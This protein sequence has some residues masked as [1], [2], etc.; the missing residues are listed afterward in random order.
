MMVDGKPGSLSDLKQGMLVRVHASV[1]E[2]YDTHEVLKRTASTLLYEDAVEGVVQSV[3]P[4]GSSLVVLGQTVTITSATIVDASIPERNVLRLV[5]GRDLVELSGFVT[6]DGTIKGT[7]VELKTV[8]MKTQPPDYEV[9]GIIKNHRAAQKTFE[10][11][12][13]TID[14]SEAKLNDMPGQ[15]SDDW[16]GLLVDA[17]G[18]QV[19]SG[20]FGSS[21]VRMKANLVWPETLGSND[22]E[23]VQVE[24]FVTQELGSGNFSIGIVRVQTNAETQFEGGTLGNI[25][26]GVRLEVHGALVGGIVKATKVELK[27]TELKGTV[28]QVLSPGDFFLGN[29][30][31]LTDVGTIFTDGTDSDIQVGAQLEVYGPLLDGIVKAVR[32]EFE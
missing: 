27:E 1:I 12:T 6:G 22:S 30:H 3:A 15:F 26:V 18:D 20:G 9:K 31:V 19:S 14:Y 13:L 11:G 7:F 32:V 8:D 10:I 2:R 16:N 21:D 17:T 5:P 24:G 25:Q 23:K 28:T 29:R 4:D